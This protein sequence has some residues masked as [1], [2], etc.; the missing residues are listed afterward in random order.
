MLPSSVF[1]KYNSD[2][3]SSYAI[4][5]I[6][7]IYKK[8]TYISNLCSLISETT[9]IILMNQ[10]SKMKPLPIFAIKVIWTENHMSHFFTQISLSHMV[11]HGFKISH[12][13]YQLVV[14]L[15][16]CRTRVTFCMVLQF[17][18]AI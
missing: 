16:S 9:D 7:M 2:L 11:S 12:G 10:D 4:Q 13:L 1:L 3:T 8:E 17:V 14:S 6:A 15:S 18:A 5:D